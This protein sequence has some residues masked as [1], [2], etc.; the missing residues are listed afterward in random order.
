ME[1]YIDGVLA[2][3]IFLALYALLLA[4]GVRLQ[5]CPS[6][7]GLPTCPS[8]P[9]TPPQD[10]RS[11]IGLLLL[12]GFLAGAAASNKYTGVL[13]GVIPLVA[14]T[15]VLSWRFKLRTSE[16]RLEPDSGTPG[17]VPHWRALAAFLV[18]AV[19][20]CAH[21]VPRDAQGDRYSLGQVF[22]RVNQVGV[23]SQWLSPI[24][25]PL[26]ALGLFAPQNRRVS[27]I[28]AGP[29]AFLFAMWFLVTHRIDRFWLPAVPLAALLAGA[30][31]AWKSSASWRIAMF[32]ILFWGLVWNFLVIAGVAAP[33]NLLVSLERLRSDPLFTAVGHLHLNKVVPP[34]DA[35]LL[36]GDAEPFDLA[37][38]A[39]Y[40]TCFDACLFE[41]WMKNKPKDQRL[42]E[43]HRRKISHVLVNWS[44]IARYRL[45]GNYGFTDYVS[46]AVFGELLQQRVLVRRQRLRDHRTGQV[47]ELFQVA[48]P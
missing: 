28:L 27:L 40:N 26:A 45:P 42:T 3:N 11:E 47:A 46:P 36:V 29:L 9:E 37:M 41:V 1:G 18:A 31:V 15:I 2:G 38:P 10:S 39:Y 5:A 24:L 16:D 33:P 21:A 14:L 44:E 6:G 43:L 12:A 19:I 8:R 4:C 23:R 30:G 22:E 32:A 48:P 17:G 34:G 7:V 13:F 35:V 20:G 25:W